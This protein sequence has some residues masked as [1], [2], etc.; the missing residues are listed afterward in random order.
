MLLA[1]YQPNRPSGSG[2]EDFKMVFTI[3][4][5]WA[6]LNFGSKPFYIFFLPLTPG[7]YI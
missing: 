4:G 3:Y 1:K 7:G 2:E 6:I 5:H